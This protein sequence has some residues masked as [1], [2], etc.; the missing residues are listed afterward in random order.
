MGEQPVPVHDLQGRISFLERRLSEVTAAAEENATAIQTSLERAEGVIQ[1]LRSRNEEMRAEV[2]QG[3]ADRRALMTLEACFQAL[4]KRAQAAEA[5]G[6]ELESAVAAESALT[7]ARA[8]LERVRGAL[9]LSAAH[10]D[11][12]ARLLAKPLERTGALLAAEG[13]QRTAALARA[14]LAAPAPATPIPVVAHPAMAP[15]RALLIGTVRGPDGEDRL[16]VAQVVGL[17][18]AQTRNDPAPAVAET[19]AGCSDPDCPDAAWHRRSLPPP[20]PGAPLARK[21]ALWDAINRYAVACG[22]DA[23]RVNVARMNAVVEVERIAFPAAAPGAPSEG[24]RGAE[25]SILDANARKAQLFDELAC[26]LPDE[27]G[28]DDQAHDQIAGVLS[29]ALSAPP[30]APAPGDGSET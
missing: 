26:L 1:A 6:S 20:A 14:A 2:M 3:R 11:D 7:A 9:E 12:A 18:T 27:T 30:A 16:E 22:G 4:L 15:G 8:E 13:A 21:V 29:R 19:T 25:Q 23:G 10:L 28:T 24:L 5:R 17:A